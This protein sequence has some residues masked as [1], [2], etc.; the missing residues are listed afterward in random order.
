M[1]AHLPLNLKNPSPTVTVG[2]VRALA[3]VDELTIHAALDAGEMPWAWDIALPGCDKREIRIWWPAARLWVAGIKE[4]PPHPITDVLDH[5]LGTTTR[6]EIRS[7][8]LRVRLVCSHNHISRLQ[9]RGCLE[10]EII[11]HT[12]ILKTESVRQWLI[13]RRLR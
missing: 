2:A 11:G 9:D 7:H 6:A 10:G 4:Q 3:G 13:A 12:R 8:E 1:Q 5:V